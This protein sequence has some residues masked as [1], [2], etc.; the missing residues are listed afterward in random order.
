MRLGDAVRRGL[1]DRRTVALAGLLIALGVVGKLLLL[2]YANIETVLV[3]SLLAGSVL[4]RWWTVLVPLGTLAILQP[5]LWGTQY[6][7]YE[8]EA[9]L[10]ITFFVVTGFV[11]VGLAGRSV[12]RRVLA[13][14][15]S[16]ALLTT[17]SVP[18]TLAYDVW[19]DIGD[20][21][22]IFRPAGIDFLTVLEWQIPFTLYHILSSLL[23]VPL[24]GSSFL[25]LAHLR[26]PEEQADATFAD[27]PDVR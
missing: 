16:V 25:V 18:L 22:F 4:G 2:R 10:G 13:R 8:I 12:R 20:W 5:I 27:P 11:F 15:G 21:Y 17:I 26:A 6:P 19:T 9:M 3:A 23:F 14:V 1:G 7:G 24:L